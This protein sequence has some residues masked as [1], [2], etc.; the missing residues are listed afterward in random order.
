MKIFTTLCVFLMLCFY[1]CHTKVDWDNL[2]FETKPT[3]NSILVPGK[4]IRV[5][6]SLAIPFGSA[7]SQTI[8]NAIVR[9]FVDNIFTETLAYDTLGF[10]QSELIVEP[11]REYRCEADIAGYNTVA[12]STV[13]PSPESIIG[14]EHIRFAGVNS[15]GITF[16]AIKVTFTNTP[17][18]QIYYEVSIKLIENEDYY[19]S[20]SIINI[21][22]PVMLNEGLPIPL[23]S[24][25]IIEGANYT[26]TLN[27]FTGAISY[28]T[29]TGSQTELFPMIIELRTLSYD[30]YKYIKTLHLY[31][32]ANSNQSITGNNRTPFSLHSNVS[33]GYG[34][35]AG[36]SSVV[37][38]TIIP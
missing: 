38:D 9:I 21:I 30:Y 3:I 31:E 15:D 5:H 4:P 26:L 1:G 11:N 37:T 2:N 34:I 23:F 10:Y 36:Y 12:A 17:S 18:K 32:K 24:N 13:I 6:V 28:T 19:G 29:E 7:K 33:N 22:D 25:E 35:F 27:Y 8:D 14:T 20:P 16:P